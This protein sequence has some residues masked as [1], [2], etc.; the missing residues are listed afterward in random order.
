MAMQWI[1]G[2]R[3][4][5]AVRV[6]NVFS[7]T[8]GWLVVWSFGFLRGEHLHGQPQCRRKTMIMG[9]SL[10]KRIWSDRGAREP[11]RGSSAISLGGPGGDRQDWIS[12]ERVAPTVVRRDTI[13]GS[14][15]GEGFVLGRWRG[16]VG[17][18]GG[19]RLGF[20]RIRK[21]VSR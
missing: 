4:E 15:R 5:N 21:E 18:M 20:I 13:L 16:F 12:W 11:T 8:G 19:C 3:V 17:D 14:W 10:G 2:L 6:L 1:W 9:L 7:A